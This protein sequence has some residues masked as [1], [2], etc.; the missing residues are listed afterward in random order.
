M[1]LSVCSPRPNNAGRAT[2]ISRFTWG[3]RSGR[4][5]GPTPATT[6]P[7]PATGASNRALKAPAAFTPPS[8]PASSS[9]G[10][11]TTRLPSDP[12]EPVVPD[13]ILRT[14]RHRQDRNRGWAPT[15]DH[16]QVP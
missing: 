3:A 4:L 15:R 14:R 12:R 6:R 7:R 2:E 8:N 13:S 10:A 16:I 1:S 11:A 9:L 5:T